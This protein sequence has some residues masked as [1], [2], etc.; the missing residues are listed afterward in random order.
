MTQIQVGIDFQTKTRT[1]IGICVVSLQNWTRKPVPQFS[2]ILVVKLELEPGPSFL[3]IIW[4]R[5]GNLL[6]V[7][8]PS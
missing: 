8:V 4:A 2:S 5:T 1:V 7:P 6:L 3:K